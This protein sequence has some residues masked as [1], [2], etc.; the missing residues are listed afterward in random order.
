M[1]IN[2]SRTSEFSI[3]QL[4]IMLD[5]MT[6]HKADLAGKF[7]RGKG[8][9]HRQKLWNQLT[10]ILNSVGDGPQK[11]ME[12]WKMVLIIIFLLNVNFIQIFF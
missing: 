5:F 3:N 11:S 2:E 8:I 10:D 4:R 9:Q 1:N 6:S 12:Q 7:R